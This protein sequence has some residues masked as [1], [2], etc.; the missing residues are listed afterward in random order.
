MTKLL[1]YYKS[2]IAV[3]IV[4]FLS[5]L[6]AENTNKVCFIDFEHSDKL[7]HF[8]MYLLLTAVLL[9]DIYNSKKKPTSM[10]TL[11]F[12][13]VILFFSGIIEIIQ[14]LLTDTRSGSFYDFIAN[15]LG[16]IV[17]YFLYFR[18]KIM[19]FFKT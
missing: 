18:T 5:L 13:T 8:F 6:P 4:L 2:I 10:L 3:I 19:S 9:I 14:E 11:S 1:K 17:G 7:I 12:L 15:F 16:I